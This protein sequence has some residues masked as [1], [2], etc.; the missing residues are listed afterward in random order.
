[1]KRLFLLDYFRGPDSTGFAA[2]RDNGDIAMAKIPSHPLDLMDMGRFK[3][4]LSG[5]NSKV[6]MGHNR[7]ATRGGVNHA[8]AHPFE[9]EHIVGMHNGTLDYSSETEIEKALG[10][11]FSVDSKG[12]IAGI[13]KL[14]IEGVVPMMRGAWSLVWYDSIEK[15][16]NF[17]RNKERPMWFAYSSD[18]KRLFWA[19]EWLM[20]DSAVRMAP[21]AAG[22]E[23]FTDEKTGYQFWPTDENIHYKFDV[24][25]LKK[26]GTERPRPKAKS[27]KGK[28][29][30]PVV[31]TGGGADPFGRQQG[32]VFVRQEGSN[33]TVMTPSTTT[34]RLSTAKTPNEHTVIHLLGDSIDP[35]AE[36]FSREKFDDLAKYGCSFCQ[37]DV[38]WGE[39]GVLIYERDDI[40]LCPDCSMSDKGA[41]KIVIKNM[42][43]LYKE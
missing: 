24:E 8:N 16:L 26:G 31:A 25:D 20:I 14:G 40:L 11:K 38:E 6:F 23:L 32:G 17:L 7:S 18:F 35:L 30:A 2:I 5:H 3:A 4:A 41:T 28:E 12:V 15:T 19:S 29:P 34:S 33:V 21:A 10:E 37:K 39:K 9:Y 1:M 42:D 13:A 22:Y 43:A 36:Y 27:L